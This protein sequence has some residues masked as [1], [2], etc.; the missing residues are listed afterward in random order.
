MIRRF[1]QIFLFSLFTTIIASAEIVPLTIL[2]QGDVHSYL[3]PDA[4]GAGGAARAAAYF[5]QVRETE[6]NVLILNTGDLVTGTPVSLVFKGE[7]VFQV[8][9]FWGLDAMILGNHEFDNGWQHIERY[10]EIANFPILCGN[11]LAMGNDGQLHVI[12]DAAYQ[13]FTKGNLRIAVLG[14]VT[15]NTPE[16]T[17]KQDTEGARFIP[18]IDAL[19]DGVKQVENQCDLIVAMTHVGIEKDPP[20]AQEVQGLD[21]ILG[22]HSHTR[23]EKEKLVNGVPIVHS[24][25]KGYCI[26]RVDL[27]VDT[28]SDSIVAFRYTLIPVDAKLGGEDAATAAEVKKWED[29]V[30]EMV[31]RPLRSAEQALS[32]QDLIMLANEAFLEASGADYSFHNSGGTRAPLAQGAF[33]YR[34]IWNIFPFENTLVTATVAGRDIPDNFFGHAAIDPTKTYKIVTN[35]YVRDQAA[36]YI[37]TLKNVTWED[38]G[39]WL[40]DAVIRYIEKRKTIH[41]VNLIR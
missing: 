21:L 7:S 22:G 25:C 5:K 19:R 27:K 30:A 2:F 40:R 26:G 23:M 4:N 35:S 9:N 15:E 34:D 24:S 29:K 1:L 14:V 13:I 28:E 8:A 6:P 17:K 41:R 36:R 12:G 33:T 38:T 32:P 37:P 10:R 39:V 18:A 31:D 3:R 16:H 11:A 20:I